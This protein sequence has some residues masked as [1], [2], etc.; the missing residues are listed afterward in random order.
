[1]A[2]TTLAVGSK[3]ELRITGLAVGGE[4]V[5]RHEGQVVFVPFSCPGD[6]IQ[7]QIQE[8]KKNF[9][10]AELIEI[11]EPGESRETP[12]CP[13]FGDCGGCAWQHVAYKEQ[14]RQKQLHVERLIRSASQTATLEPIVPS[15]PWNYRNRIQLHVQ[16]DRVGF[17]ARK[18]HRL[19]PSKDCKIAD[20]K[21]VQYMEN[22]ESEVIAEA[23][24]RGVQRFEIGTGPSG[25]IFV[26]WLGDK[27]PE[28]QQV[29]NEI[30]KKLNDCVLQTLGECKETQMYDL[31]CGAGN[32]GLLVAKTF[33]NK[34]I[35]GVERSPTLVEKAR[36]AAKNLGLTN[37]G[38][39]SGDVKEFLRE[40]K[41]LEGLVLLDP[42]RA[43]CD[44]AVLN[45]L[46]ASQVSMI[47]YISCHPA[48]AIRD[49]KVLSPEFQLSSVQPFDMFPQTDHVELV[50]ILRHRSLSSQG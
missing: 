32:F 35:I 26:D 34:S 13:V 44:E 20:K 43:G 29:N 37:I 50:G 21:I 25:K 49:W 48:T 27:Q 2:K 42:P 30:N 8:N 15:H 10:R 31:F 23:Q 3:I 14:L 22:H 4:G 9:L 28:F 41:S 7:V 6:L 45:L 40:E 18:S 5:G 17:L 39:H 38:F 33:K 16:N 47:L 46:K 19:V 1:M 36:Q 24:S 11:I 12:P